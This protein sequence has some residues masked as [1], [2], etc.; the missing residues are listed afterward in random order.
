M[1][2]SLFALHILPDIHASVSASPPNDTALRIQSSY[3][4]LSY[5]QVKHAGTEHWQM[6]KNLCVLCE[7]IQR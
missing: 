6:H 5:Q 1:Q 4:L 7:L 3:E 2:V